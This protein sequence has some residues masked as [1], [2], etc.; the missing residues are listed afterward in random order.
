MRKTLIAAAAALA[1]TAIPATVALAQLPAPHATATVTITPGDAGTKRHPHNAQFHLFVQNNVESQTTASEIEITIPRKVKVSG[2]GLRKCDKTALAANGPDACPSKSSAGSGLAHALVNPHSADPFELTLD[3]S[4]FIGGKKKLL[5]FVQGRE[6]P[7][8]VGIFDAPLR[9]LSNGKQQMRVKI[10]T[11]LQQPAPGTYSALVDLE[12]TL[13]RKRGDHYL[14]RTIG[15]KGGSHNFG[16]ALVYV[17]NPTPP[18]ASRSETTAQ[19]PCT[20]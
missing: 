10:P 18:A 3:V 15:C 13:S 14:F 4:V 8:V 9:T 17:P 19:A 16:I 5:F 11:N 2:K 12:T 1:I 7:E 20:K 6:L